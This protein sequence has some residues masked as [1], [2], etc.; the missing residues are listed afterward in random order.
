M[1]D[2]WF[3]KR[4]RALASL[5][6]LDSPKRSFR[7][8]RAY[9]GEGLFLNMGYALWRMTAELYGFVEESTTMQCSI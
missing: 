6:Q 5:K 7:H 8:I 1:V 3:D 2:R 9:M 4:P